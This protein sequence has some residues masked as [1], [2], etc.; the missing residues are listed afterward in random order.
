MTFCKWY[1]FVWVCVGI[2]I[3]FGV[4]GWGADTA[5]Q[6]NQRRNALLSVVVLI[7]VL[8]YMGRAVGLW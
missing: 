4:A 5:S 7:P 6:T 2:V 1:T 8:I 3:E